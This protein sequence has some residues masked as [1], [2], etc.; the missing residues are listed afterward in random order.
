MFRFFAHI[1]LIF[2]ILSSCGNESTPLQDVEKQ[3]NNLINDGS[4][5]TIIIISDLDC[6]TCLEYITPKLDI[7]SKPLFG[8]FLVSHKKTVKS[9]ND[10]I[11]KTGNK[12]KWTNSSNIPLANSLTILWKN[13]PKPSF[14]EL[15]NKKIVRYGLL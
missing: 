10:W 5:K 2:L 3:L 4:S 8:I 13:D 11:I 9:Y 12:V 14:F 6:V 1:S 15:R 7:L